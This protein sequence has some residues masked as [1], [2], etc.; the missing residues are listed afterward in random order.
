V[1]V[2]VE[3]AVAQLDYHPDQVARSLKGKMMKRLG[4]VLSDI[5]SPFFAQ[6]LRGAEECALA[7]GY[8]MITLNSDDKS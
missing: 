2:R 1:R 8:V 4:L 7:N 5:T 6:V 3:A